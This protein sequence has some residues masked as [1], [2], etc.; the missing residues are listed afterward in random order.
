[1]RVNE[2]NSIAKDELKIIVKGTNNDM[3]QIIILIYMVKTIT[4]IDIKEMILIVKI[5]QKIYLTAI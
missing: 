3:I 5:N 1:M 2:Q 4:F